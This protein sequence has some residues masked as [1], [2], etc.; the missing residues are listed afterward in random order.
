MT[1]SPPAI[2]R[3]AAAP[4][5]WGVC[6]VTGWGHQMGADRVLSEIAELGFAGTEAG[7][8]GFLPADPIAVRDRCAELRLA[9]VAGFV[10]VVLHRA[11]L[12]D[13]PQVAARARWLAAAG[14]DVLVLACTTGLEGYDRVP[15][16]DVADRARLAAGVAAACGIA[17]EHGLTPA[18]HPH[19]GTVVE[20]P[21]AVAHLL[22]VTTVPL[23]LDTGHLLIGGVD[24][25]GLAADA[26]ERIAHVQLKDV[27]AA[28]A[29]AVRAGERTYTSAVADGVYRP[30][31]AGDVDLVAVI[32]HLEPTYR[33]WY[34][35]EQ[36]VI[37]AQ[38]PPPDS[39]P[40]ADVAV[41]RDHLAHLLT[42]RESTPT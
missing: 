39:G 38:E 19:V 21:D 8:D 30:L 17:R 32:E 11:D 14:A 37:L 4:I 34:V 5:S 33:G 24:P 26:A 3:I 1:I 35:L 7:P 9:L 13:L 31:G 40:R 25:V 10:P 28:L 18:L 41:S 42:A 20:G 22:E 27:D 29:A 16:L 12:D 6:E 23:C 36:D 2:Q 15:P